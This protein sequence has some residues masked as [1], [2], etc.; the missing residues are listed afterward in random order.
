MSISA[1][2]TVRVAII[3]CSGIATKKSMP[4]LAKLDNIKM[5]GFCDMIEDRALAAKGRFGTAD[6][7]ACTD[8]RRLLEDK[9]TMR[10]RHRNPP[11]IARQAPG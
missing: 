11:L 6:S 4:A 2:D 3:G 10:A 7:I 9:P 8:Y 5:V 1:S